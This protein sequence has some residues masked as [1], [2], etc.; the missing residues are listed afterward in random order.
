MQVRRFPLLVV[1]FVCVILFA[2]WFLF[3]SVEIDTERNGKATLH[4]R[5]GALHKIAFDA[6]RDGSVDGVDVLGKGAVL[7]LSETWQSRLSWIDVDYDGK[8]DAEWETIRRNG[9]TVRVYWFDDDGDGRLD[10][11][12]VGDAGSERLSEMVGERQHR[13]KSIRKNSK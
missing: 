12:F 13:L 3:R 2:F 9:T 8:V 5:W 1:L 6:N 7:D 4:Y 10:D 11:V